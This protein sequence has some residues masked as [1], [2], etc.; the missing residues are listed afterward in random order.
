M[1]R[2][3]KVVEPSFPLSLTDLH[4]VAPNDL[5]SGHLVLPPLLTSLVL[6]TDHVPKS[7]WTENENSEVSKRFGFTRFPHITESGIIDDDDLRSFALPGP[8]L[9]LTRLHIVPFNEQKFREGPFELPL[10]WDFSRYNSI[11]LLCASSTNISLQALSRLN[12]LQSLSIDLQNLKPNLLPPTLSHLAL[13]TNAI[14][15]NTL[16]SLPLTLTSLHLLETD[17]TEGLLSNVQLRHLKSLKWEI[18]D[19]KL[20]LLSV[21]SWR[22][23]EMFPFLEELEL[24]MGLDASDEF[25]FSLLSSTLRKLHIKGTIEQPHPKFLHCLPKYLSSLLLNLEK[26]EDDQIASLPRFL[27][28]L[29]FPITKTLTKACFAHLPRTLNRLDVMVENQRY[30]AYDIQKCL[31]SLRKA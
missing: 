18:K 1:N 13:R 19:K 25:V 31:N 7:L 22:H 15:A 20:P 2:N 27:R 30:S 4:L 10:A 21:I 3:H 16:R 5:G 26:I 17:S 8:P 29:A 9:N 6:V 11:D 23:I 14:S 24:D 12:R 28:N